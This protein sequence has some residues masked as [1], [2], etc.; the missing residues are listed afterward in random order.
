[1]K[2]NKKLLGLALLL[3]LATFLGACQPNADE[4]VDPGAPAVDP[5]ESPAE[6]GNRDEPV[7]PNAPAVDPAEKKPNP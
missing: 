3:S 1:M 6:P 2:K 7:D 5:A 4:P